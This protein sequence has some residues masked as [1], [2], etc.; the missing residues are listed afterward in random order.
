[1][2]RALDAVRHGGVALALVAAA[3]LFSAV[4]QADAA[5]EYDAF[6]YS[7]YALSASYNAYLREGI[8]QYYYD[9]YLYSYYGNYYADYAYNNFADVY[10]YNAYEYHYY[11]YQYFDY[12]YS[13]YGGTRTYRALLYNYYALYYSYYAYVT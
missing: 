4:P 9:A 3:A 13:A 7:Q 10:F 2:F 12:L 8:D 5:Y 11:S 6:V 1:M